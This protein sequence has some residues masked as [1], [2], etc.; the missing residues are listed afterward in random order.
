MSSFFMLVTLVPLT[1]V[2]A[3]SFIG[4]S[5]AASGAVASPSSF[6]SSSAKLAVSQPVR[7]SSLGSISTAVEL[8]LLME[9]A[10]AVAALESTSSTLPVCGGD[11]GTDY[12]VAR[13]NIGIILGIA[14]VVI[15]NTDFIYHHPAIFDVT[16]GSAAS[17]SVSAARNGLTS[18]SA[19]TMR[20]TFV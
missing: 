18:G 20:S 9:A 12:P 3:S 13:N 2:V 16:N 19:V 17:S 10:A 11:G 14:N 7:P 1:A 5:S 15:T 4:V 6:N 8:L